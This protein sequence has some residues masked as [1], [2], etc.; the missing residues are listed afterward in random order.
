LK[1]CSKCIIIEA[2]SSIGGGVMNHIIQIRNLNYGYHDTMLFDHF[3]LMIQKETFTSIVGKNGSGKSTLLKILCGLKK[4]DANIHIGGYQLCGKNICGI[5]KQIGVL[6]ETGC[7]S[8]AKKTVKEE[9]SFPLENLN[10]TIERIDEAVEKISKQLKLQHIL[11]KPVEQLY[12][13]ERQRLRLATALITRPTILLLDQPYLGLSEEEKKIVV[14]VLKKCHT[15]EHMTIIQMVEDL[16]DSLYGDDIVILSD[17]KAV[18]FDQ[19][20]KV[21]SETKILKAAG[22]QLPFVV[23][24]SNKLKYYELVD[25]V[26]LNMDEMVDVIWK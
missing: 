13:G 9:L 3:N 23:N 8:F 24:L 12:R 19:K 4:A 11:E 16:E 1:N 2:F 17:G 10:W 6:L 25:D 18:L 5:R 21:L 26:M 22:L 15:K 7:D 20:E 14:S